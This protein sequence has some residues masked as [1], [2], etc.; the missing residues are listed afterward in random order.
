MTDAAGPQPSEPRR[1][2]RGAVIAALLIGA[3]IG[4]MSVEYWLAKWGASRPS[5]Q[6]QPTGAAAQ[7]LDR[8]KQIAPTQSHTM[9]DVGYHWA[10]LWFAAQKKNWPLANY[11][12]HEARQAVRWTV[13]IRPTRQLPGGGTFD[14]KGMFAG[15]DPTAFNDVMLAINDEDSAQFEKTYKDALLSCHACH[16]AAGLPFLKPVV[17]ASP[18][19]SILTYEP[20]PAE[21]Q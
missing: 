5:A 21:K 11:Y 20:V 16:T 8:L 19:T 3:I 10:N 14:M 13:M 18:S 7:D 2:S 15:I 4:G 9:Q 6:E 17:P 12:F 1:V